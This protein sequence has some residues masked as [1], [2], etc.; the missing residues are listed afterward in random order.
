MDKVTHK[1]MDTQGRPDIQRDAESNT[2]AHT[3][4]G[5]Q[6]QSG[7][8]AGARDSGAE[9]GRKPRDRRSG[10]AETGRWATQAMVNGTDAR[11]IWQPCT[12]ADTR[13]RACMDGWPPKQAKS[14]EWMQ[15]TPQM[16]SD[17]DLGTKKSHRPAEGGQ[18]GSAPYFLG[19]LLDRPCRLTG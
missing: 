3:A 18:W 5:P 10:V 8:W 17:K 4:S 7:P 1:G 11:G 12:Q 15:K 14:R 9:A 19:T 13:P 2:D 6:T 16:A